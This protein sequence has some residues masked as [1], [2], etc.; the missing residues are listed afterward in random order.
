M[1][2]NKGP[3]RPLRKYPF[4]E[5]SQRIFRRWIYSTPLFLCVLAAGIIYCSVNEQIPIA[6]LFA[7]I[8]CLA[9]LEC[10]ILYLHFRNKCRR[11][12]LL[13]TSNDFTIVLVVQRA[14]GFNVMKAESIYI[15]FFRDS[16]IAQQYAAV[17]ALLLHQS[18]PKHVRQQAL[19]KRCAMEKNSRGD[20]FPYAP[21]D[22]YDLQGKTILI[23]RNVIEYYGEPD[24]VRLTQNGCTLSVLDEPAEE[25]QVSA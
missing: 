4:S 22:L 18:T 1:Q 25:T 21:V 5:S 17:N 2:K 3:H 6:I 15:R 20:S 14:F 16:E 23:A 9:F 8:G 12:A 13:S 11:F 7:A 19:K 24:S 10:L